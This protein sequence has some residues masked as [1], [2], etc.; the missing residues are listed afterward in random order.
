[1]RKNFPQ[2]KRS[3]K[4][5]DREMNLIMD[6]NKNPDGGGVW[7]RVTASQARKMQVHLGAGG[8]AGI[9]DEDLE[10]MVKAVGGGTGAS[11]TEK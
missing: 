10:D 8:K 3:V 11:G 9:S 4:F 1:M 7:K 5:D 6:F 2:M